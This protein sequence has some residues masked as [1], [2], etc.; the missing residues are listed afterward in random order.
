LHFDLALG[1]D[2]HFALDLLHL[3]WWNVLSCE[4]GL[5][6]G[7]WHERDWSFDHAYEKDLSFDLAYERDCCCGPVRVLHHS[8]FAQSSD[9]DYRSVLARDLHHF[10]FV[11]F[12]D[13]DFDFD[14]SQVL[15]HFCFDQ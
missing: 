9:S 10:Y 3:D 8:C 5:N 15:L 7:L 4:T 12:L 13:W 1:M 11:L 2:W 6:F 14:L